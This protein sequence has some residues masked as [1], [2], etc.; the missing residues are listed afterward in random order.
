MAVRK[1]ASTSSRRSKILIDRGNR[2]LLATAS[3]QLPYGKF[4]SIFSIKWTFLVAIG[5]FEIG[6]LI[7]GAAQTSTVLIIGRAIAGLGCAGIFTGALI[8][9]AYTMPLQYR[10]MYAGAVGAVS[11][12]AA[13]CGPLLG[14][15]FTDKVTWRWCFYV[16]LPLGGL[17][18][19]VIAL[20]TP[21]MHS[22]KSRKMPFTERLEKFD[23]LGTFFFIPSIICCLL[24]LQWGGAVYAWD[25]AR[26]VTLFM[27]SFVLFAVFVGIQLWKKDD[28]TLPLRILR[29]RSVAG[30]AAFSFG[31]GAAFFIAIFYVSKTY[32]Y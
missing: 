25:S 12:I 28:A 16:N 8:I 5:I 6:S 15:A 32:A 1:V 19:A 24:A 26:V 2:Y 9:A 17:T 3:F 10:P 13:I 23:I 14:G 27:T 7:C 20:L 21:Q 30:A 22:K 18:I 4:Y 31:I 29:Q 11:G